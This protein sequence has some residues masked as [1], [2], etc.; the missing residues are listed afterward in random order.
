MTLSTLTQQLDTLGFSGFKAALLRQSDDAN[1]AQL[2]FEERLYQLLE[3][4]QSERKD[5]K[6]KRLLSQAKLKERQASLEQ[7]EVTP[8]ITPPSQ[9]KAKL[10]TRNNPHFSPV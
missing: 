2:P 9:H 4:E 8:K 10:F 6:I 1:Y 7:V 3:A 5:K